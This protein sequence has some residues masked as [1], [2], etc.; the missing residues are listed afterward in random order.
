MKKKDEK[1][2]MVNDYDY[3][4]YSPDFKRM[5]KDLLITGVCFLIIGIIILQLLLDEW[6]QGQT[7]LI[8]GAYIFGGIFG[9][10]L[11]WVGVVRSQMV[12]FRFGE[13]EHFTSY[14]QKLQVVIWKFRKRSVMALPFLLYAFW[15]VSHLINKSIPVGGN[16]AAIC[17]LTILSMTCIFGFSMWVLSWQVYLSLGQEIKSHEKGRR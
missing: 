2:L 6:R 4:T 3:H 10:L 8:L 16:Y 17:Y 9:V 5:Q 13:P 1:Q 7:L 12:G 15:L 14:E 11:P